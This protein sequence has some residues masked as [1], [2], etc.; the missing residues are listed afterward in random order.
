MC[1]LLRLSENSEDFKFD[2]F[3]FGNFGVI[4]QPWCASMMCSACLPQR[5]F[6][7]LSTSANGHVS[8]IISWTDSSLKSYIFIC[9]ACFQTTSKNKLPVIR[10]LGKQT[11]R[12]LYMYPALEICV[13]KKE[14][15]PLPYFQFL[16]PVVLEW[17]VNGSL[18]TFAS[19]GMT[20]ALGIS[21]DI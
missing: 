10:N 15:H 7:N 12:D 11:R 20:G 3:L 1:F 4:R 9:L 19:Q 17:V 16:L 18:N 21:M 2:G 6:L 5:F 14:N 13:Q 8:E